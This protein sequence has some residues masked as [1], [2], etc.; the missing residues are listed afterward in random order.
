[1]TIDF[2]RHNKGYITATDSMN[3]VETVTV[4]YQVKTGSRNEELV[5]NGLS[6]FLEHMAFK[7]TKTKSALEIAQKFDEIGGRFNAYTSRENTVYYAKVLKD[8]LPIAIDILSDILQN[9]VYAEDEIKREKEVI[10]QEIAQTNDAPD[11]LIF[12][13]F[14]E[15]AYPEQSFG[16]SILGTVDHV[17]NVTQKQILSYVERNHFN[18]NLVVSAAGK[19]TFEHLQNLLDERFA[20]FASQNNKFNSKAEY[21]GGEVRLDK[22]LE[23]VHVVFG[24]NCVDFYDEDFYAYQV[25]SLI[26]GG[27][28]SSRLFQEIRERRGLVYS[29]SSF[30]SHYT[31]TGMFG[32]YGATTPDNANEFIAVAIAELKKMIDTVTDDEL[33]RAKSQVRASLLMGQES[34]VARAEKLGHFIS[35]FNRYITIEEV[36]QEISKIDR[37]RLSSC[38]Q[39]LL[40]QKSLPTLASIGKTAKLISYEKFIDLVKG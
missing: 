30:S 15:K 1:M 19:L 10:L 39:K 25:L 32:V 36:L 21:V 6:H 9:S 8:D 4:M 31:D 26:A 28:M 35:A 18:E 37:K 33:A 17:S 2:K 22:D 16:R 3:D 12:D 29:V 24:F 34:T 13:M 38:L 14:Q 40:S 27:G 11:D 5:D 20:G 7:G 23:Q